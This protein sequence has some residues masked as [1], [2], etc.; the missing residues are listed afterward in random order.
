[1]ILQSA[2]RIYL[3]G[4]FYDSFFRSFLEGDIIKWDREPWV[5]R[6]P[7]RRSEEEI[8]DLEKDICTQDQKGLF[9]A[10]KKFD[11]KESIHVCK[12]I[13]GNM[14]SYTNKDDFEKFVNFLSLSRNMKSSDCIETLQDVNRI[15][16]WGGGNDE[17]VE[18]IWKTWNNQ[19]IIMVSINKLILFS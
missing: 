9:M 7:Y 1:M 6:S 5:L 12:K 19:K 10:P 2:G 8:L 17:V 11:F 13:S 3:I 16:S 15:M 4:T 14:I 18:G